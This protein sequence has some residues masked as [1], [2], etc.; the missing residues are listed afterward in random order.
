[1]VFTIN[2]QE[3]KNGWLAGQCEQLPEAISQD[4]DMD[5]L[6]VNMK[7]AIELCLEYKQ[8]QFRLQNNSGNVMPL[9]FKHEKKRIAKTSQRKRVYA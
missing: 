4:K 2:I 7:D 1:M 9:I 5:D 8:Q 6:M 3:S